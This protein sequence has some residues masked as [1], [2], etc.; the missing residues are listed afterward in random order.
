[1]D[2]LRTLPHTQL[3]RCG[4]PRKVHPGF[5]TRRYAV[6]AGRGRAGPKAE[7]KAAEPQ[8]TGS[9]QHINP[10]NLRVP[11]PQTG[12]HLG[13]LYALQRAVAWSQRVWPR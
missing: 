9:Q 3:S 8:A 1:M 13:L 5:L 10:V 7:A 4:F 11:T 2:A 6:A 12:A